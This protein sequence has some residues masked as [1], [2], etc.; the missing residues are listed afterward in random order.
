M[1]DW[2]IPCNLKYYDVVGAFSNLKCIDWKQSAKS[3]EIGD[4]VYIYVGRPQMAIR[5]K[6][7]V[8][9]VNLDKIEIDDS[10]YIVNGEPY[11][12][13]GNH[14]ELELVKTYNSDELS[15][16]ILRE[17]G[18]KGNIQGPRKIDGDLLLYIS[19]II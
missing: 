19:K 5:Y 15:L 16:S 12:E 14:M 1:A 2:V 11:A 17:Y 4:I 3:I 18:L 8:N 9:K 10:K 7:K 6:C 13:Y